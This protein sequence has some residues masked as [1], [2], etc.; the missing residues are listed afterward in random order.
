MR[1]QAVEV[2]IVGGGLAGSALAAVLARLGRSVALFDL[3]ASY[4]EVFRAEKLT[5]RQVTALCRLDLAGP[6]LA[7]ATP[8]DE[9]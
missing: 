6:V 1:R 3:H 2:A 8:I 4:P 5:A 7:V 9:L